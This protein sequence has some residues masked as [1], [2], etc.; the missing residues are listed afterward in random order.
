MNDVYFFTTAV[1]GDEGVGGCWNR[2]ASL[3][4]NK[5][6]WIGIMDADVM[7]FPHNWPDRVVQA[8]NSEEGK[9]FAVITCMATRTYHKSDQQFH[10]ETKYGVPIRELR[11]IVRLAEIS[12]RQF[13]IPNRGD[14][15]AP[16]IRMRTGFS[17]FFFVFKKSLWLKYPF[18]SVGIKGHK[19]VGVETAWDRKIR[20]AGYRVGLIPSLLAVHYYRFNK[21]DRDATHLED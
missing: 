15:T 9:E 5:D 20:K 19:N 10:G 7:L 4:P 16:V 1:I 3:V 14:I 8:I 21:H 11:D 6:D 17:A 13:E 2:I 12:E 18:P